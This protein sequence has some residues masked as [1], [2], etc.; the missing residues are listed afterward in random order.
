MSRPRTTLARV[1]DNDIVIVVDR[2]RQLI[3]RAFSSEYY[4]SLHHNNYMLGMPGR[5][6][7]Q[8]AQ[9][10]AERE[11]R[12]VDRERANSPG[13]H[14]DVYNDKDAGKYKKGNGASGRLSGHRSHPA[15]PCRGRPRP[16]PLTLRPGCRRAA[17]QVAL[18]KAKL[19]GEGEDEDEDEGEEDEPLVRVDAYHPRMKRQSDVE[20]LSCSTEAERVPTGGTCKVTKCKAARGEVECVKKKCV[21]K[22][23]SCLSAD[24]KCA[25]MACAQ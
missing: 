10:A 5:F 9:E 13:G 24:K 18:M 21:C 11:Q 14:P 15:C 20:S 4:V 1:H 22:P 6:R 23:G 25:S 19:E 7:K 8:E 17:G 2:A 12:R 3:S 16:S